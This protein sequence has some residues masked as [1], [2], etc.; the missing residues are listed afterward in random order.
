MVYWRK[1]I[2]RAVKDIREDKSLALVEVWSHKLGGIYAYRKLLRAKW[3]E[4]LESLNEADCLVGDWNAHNQ[5][6]DPLNE[7]DTQGKEMEK[8]IVEN[9]FE[10]GGEYDEPTWKRIINGRK[11][12]SWI[13]LFICRGPK[14]SQKV[15]SDKF[16]S[17]H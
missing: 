17:D 11:Q 15:K 9:G 10:I 8:W 1:K 14:N 7:D 6:W 13:D 2:D 16:L 5:A 3:R 12:Q 4:W